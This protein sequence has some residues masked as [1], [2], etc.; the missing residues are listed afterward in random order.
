VDGVPCL[1]LDGDVPVPHGLY[2]MREIL[3]LYTSVSFGWWL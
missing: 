2:V 1:F 3:T